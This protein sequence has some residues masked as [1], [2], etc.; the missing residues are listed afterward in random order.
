M[1]RVCCADKVNSWVDKAGS[2][3]TTYEWEVVTSPGLTR[4]AS[5]S[6]AVN[7]CTETAVCTGTDDLR[8]CFGITTDN[9]NLAGELLAL[10]SGSPDVQPALACL[11]AQPFRIPACCL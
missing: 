11:P 6:V 2:C 9:L 8:G 1:P 4:V 7:P 3:E 10:F 5:S